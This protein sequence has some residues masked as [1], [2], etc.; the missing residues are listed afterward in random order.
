LLGAGPDDS[1]GELSLGN[2]GQDSGAQ[3]IRVNS[4]T[5]RNLLNGLPKPSGPRHV[6]LA[7]NIVNGDLFRWQWMWGRVADRFGIEAAP[8]DGK[9]RP[10]EQRML[11]RQF[12]K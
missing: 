6:A 3:N 1:D 5:M 2:A 7:F 12:Q 10:L 8:F 11:R 9:V 4:A